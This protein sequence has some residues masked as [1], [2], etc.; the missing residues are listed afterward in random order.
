MFT[1]TAGTANPATATAATRAPGRRHGRR[2]HGRRDVRRGADQR[3]EPR[4][5]SRRRVRQLR[6]RRAQRHPGKRPASTTSTAAAASSAS[7][8]RPSSRR[9]TPLFDTLIGL[10]GATAHDG[11][12]RGQ[13]AGRRVPRPRAPRDA[14]PRPRCVKG[15][16]DNYYQWTNNPT[17]HVHTVARVRFN[18]IPVKP[19][20]GQD[21]A[22]IL[23]ES[24]TNDA[25]TRFTGSD[26][27]DPAAAASARCPGAVTSSRAARS[28]PA[29]ARPSPRTTRRCNKHLG[30]RRPVGGRHGPRR[31]QGDDQLE[32]HADAPDAV[33]PDDAGPADERLDGEL[34]P[35]HG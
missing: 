34:Q 25:V 21:P 19:K 14:R 30:V 22:T 8:R 13:H 5:L 24:V 15:R 7:A 32:L 1:G 9:A 4:G 2:L 28:T 12:E 27:H 29:W 3:G 23:R 18:T 10:T 33:E 11:R 26:Q 31:L 17:G 6:G 20:V 16:A 35:V